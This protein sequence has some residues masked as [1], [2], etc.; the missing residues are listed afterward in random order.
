MNLN[1]QTS[2]SPSAL[3]IG[4][5]PAGLTIAGQ[6]AFRNQPFTVL[7][8]SEHIGFAWRNY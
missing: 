6:L 1:T 4:A 3:V 2:K 7:E 5:G 8:A